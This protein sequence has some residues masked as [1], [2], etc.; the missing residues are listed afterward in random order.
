MKR[1]DTGF[2]GKT[3][4]PFSAKLNTIEMGKVAVDIFELLR[5]QK[6]FYKE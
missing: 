1:D 4:Y 3:A 6:L 5:N 2:M